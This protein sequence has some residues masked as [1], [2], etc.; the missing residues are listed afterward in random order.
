MKT[1]YTLILVLLAGAAYGQ[2]G[3]WIQT[4]PSGCKAFTW[5]DGSVDIQW[6]GGCKDGL[7]HGLGSFKLY[8]DKKLA[9]SA[10]GNYL[11]GKSNGKATYTWPNGDKHEG[12]F[13]DGKAN[14]QGTYTHPNGDKYV[15]EFKDSKRHGQGTYFR[16]DGRIGLGEWFENK[17]SGQFIEYRADKTVVRS[18]IGTVYSVI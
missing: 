15:G 17:P 9:Y 7:V 5:R 16:K 2:T 13:K 8:L 12:E 6:D 11:E 4:T 10:V 18:G 3:Q 1:F 14:G